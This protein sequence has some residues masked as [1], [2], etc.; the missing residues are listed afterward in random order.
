MARE[1]RHAL[2]EIEQPRLMCGVIGA[3]PGPRLQT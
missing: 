3:L 1:L 2:R